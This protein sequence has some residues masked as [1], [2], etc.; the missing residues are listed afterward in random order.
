MKKLANIMLLISLSLIYGCVKDIPLAADSASQAAGDGRANEN[1]AYCSLETTSPTDALLQCNIQNTGLKDYL[2]SG[3]SQG[4]HHFSYASQYAIENDM[5]DMNYW[6]S[7][8]INKH[9]MLNVTFRTYV[10]WTADAFDVAAADLEMRIASN[11]CPGFSIGHV[12]ASFTNMNAIIK[13]EAPRTISARGKTI[14]T[15]P[16]GGPS[17]PVITRTP[18]NPNLDLIEEMKLRWQGKPYTLRFQVGEAKKL[19]NITASDSCGTQSEFC[20]D[21]ASAPFAEEVRRWFTPKDTVCHIPPE[22]K[23]ENFRYCNSGHGT[24]TGNYVD[25]FHMMQHQTP[26]LSQIT[27][28]RDPEGCASNDGNFESKTIQMDKPRCWLYKVDTGG[29][30]G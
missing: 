9:N 11:D 5:V 25:S 14:C 15:T 4:R 24:P 12:V 28:L 3:L 29:Y 2:I 8:C 20:T 27:S 23:N 19:F 13:D 10:P 1:A 22:Q 7:D 21:F 26:G 6:N 17:E 18:I 16:S 30:C